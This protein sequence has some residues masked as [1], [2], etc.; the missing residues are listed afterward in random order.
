MLCTESNRRPSTPYSSIQVRHASIKN[1]SGILF[2][3]HE[4]Q[5][6]EPASSNPALLLCGMQSACPKA[7]R[8]V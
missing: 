4:I 1:A 6:G 7:W 5:Y 8:C 2:A 3:M